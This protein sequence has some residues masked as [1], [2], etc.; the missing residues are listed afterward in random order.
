MAQPRLEDKLAALAALDLAADAAI[1]LLRQAL[2]DKSNLVAGKAAR[3]VSRANLSSLAADLETA[4]RRFLVNPATTD[5]GCQAKLPIA[6]C[7][8][9]LGIGSEEI[10]LAGIHH[11][12]L[13]R[14]FGPPIDTAAELRGTC[15]LGLVRRGYADILSELASLL[16]DPQRPARLLA[17]RAA[18]YT[19]SEL[20]APLLR[21]RILAGDSDPELLAEC[22]TAL[23]TLTPTK[24]LRLVGSYLDHADADLAT[25][26]ALA[27]AGARSP[28]AAECLLSHW[29]RHINPDTRQRLL[30]PLAMLRHPRAIDKLLAVIADAPAPMACAAIE[31]MALYRNDQAL[32]PRLLAAAEGRDRA[33]TDAARRVFS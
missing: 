5:K 12:Q 26:A 23:L 22:F 32:R 21:M 18:A 14:S 1:P 11:V 29:D 16:M 9:E 17:A 13:E 19:G 24:G 30:L 33:V 6:Q 4:F 31:A 15:A 27:I 25:E 7:L 8:Y 20:A 2:A 28:E 3:L 10:F